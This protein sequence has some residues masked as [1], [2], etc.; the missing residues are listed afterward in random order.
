MR[1]PRQSKAPRILRVSSSGDKAHLLALAK[2]DGVSL[3]PP[4]LDGREVVAVFEDRADLKPNYIMWLEWRDGQ[5]SFLRDYRYV[6]Y[7]AAD[8]ELTLA[9]PSKRAD[10]GAAQ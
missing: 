3:A 4:W 10:G 8:A 1:R 9:S 5:I 2:I 7:V 6:R